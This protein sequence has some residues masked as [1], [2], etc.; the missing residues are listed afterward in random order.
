MRLNLATARL[1]VYKPLPA[2]VVANKGILM[3]K[4]FAG[5]RSTMSV[6]MRSSL[7]VLAFAGVGAGLAGCTTVE[8]TNALTDPGTFEREVMTSTLQGLGMVDKP[9]VGEKKDTRGPLVLPKDASLP[10]PAEAKADAAL[11]Q[12]PED[13]DKVKVDMTGL[14]KEDISR[15]NGALVFDPITSSGRPMTQAEIAQLTAKAKNVLVK[16]GARPLYLPPEEYFTTVKGQDLVC[17]APNGDL[18]PLD[19]PTCPPEVKK[20]LAKKLANN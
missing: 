4:A 6:F 5:H 2:G 15:I 9:K 13:S 14:S 18:V 10:P 8:G 11:A 17:L 19:D 20:A 1:L 7:L 12:L 16:K 3:L